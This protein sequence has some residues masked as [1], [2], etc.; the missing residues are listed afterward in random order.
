LTAAAAVP[1]TTQRA[2]HHLNRPSPKF[3]KIENIAPSAPADRPLHS[4]SLAATQR[5]LPWPQALLPHPLTPWPTAYLGTAVGVA[6]LARRSNRALAPARP[7]RSTRSSSTVRAAGPKRGCTRLQCQGVERRV[8]GPGA[9]SLVARHAATSAPCPYAARVRRAG[10]TAGFAAVVGTIL[11]G[12]YGTMTGRQQLYSRMLR[13]RLVL[14]V[15]SVLGMGERGRLAGQAGGGAELS[16]PAACRGLQLAAQ[17]LVMCDTEAQISVPQHLQLPTCGGR[18]WRR[19]RGSA[20]A[21]S[22][23]AHLLLAPHQ[24]MQGTTLGLYVTGTGFFP[25]PA[26]VVAVF[27]PPTRP[28]LQ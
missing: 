24:R 17:I 13:A 11:A 19:R 7:P 1:P 18:C 10:C 21:A 8:G 14:V 2:R 12:V 22:P 23:P 5:R 16:P 28:P 9:P 20:P 27:G 4:T 3:L 6:R 25:V 26:P 15:R